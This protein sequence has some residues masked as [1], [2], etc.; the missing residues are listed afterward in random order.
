MF[1]LTYYP[2]N[3]FYFILGLIQ[4][5]IALP[6]PNTQIFRRI[7]HTINYRGALETN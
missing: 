1:A 6:T 3:K 5:P 4:L 7:F 2:Q